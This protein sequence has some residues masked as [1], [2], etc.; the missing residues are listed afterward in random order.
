MALETDNTKHFPFANY[1]ILRVSNIF[2]F[3]VASH[4]QLERH[5]QY[6]TTID[7]MLTFKRLS[8]YALP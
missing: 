4:Y 8:E 2:H 7:A 5:C 3:L 1:Y 6:K